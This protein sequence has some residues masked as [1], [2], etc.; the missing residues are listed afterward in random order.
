M[1][2][3]NNNNQGYIR[4]CDSKRIAGIQVYKAKLAIGGGSSNNAATTASAASTKKKNRWSIIPKQIRLYNA[5]FIIIY[6]FQII[7]VLL[8]MG[9]PYNEFIAKADVEGFQV[10]EGNTRLRAEFTHYFKEINAADRRIQKIGWNDWKHM[11]IEELVQE[12]KKDR[13][14]TVLDSIP[15]HMRIPGKYQTSFWPTLLFGMLCTI[16]AFILLLQHWNVQFNIYMNYIECDINQSIDILNRLYPNIM[17]INAITNPNDDN[18]SKKDNASKSSSSNIKYKL[19][20]NGNPIIFHNYEMTDTMSSNS[21]N[22]PTHAKIISSKKTE[23]DVLVPILFYPSL[24]MCIEYHRRKYIYNATEQIWSKIRCRTNFTLSLLYNTKQQQESKSNQK[25]W[26]GFPSIQQMIAAQIR[27]GPNIFQVKQPTFIEMYKVQLL[28][29]FSVFQIFCVLL[30]AIDSYIMY[31]MFSLFMIFMFEGTVVFQRLQSFKALQSMGNKNRIIYVYRCYQWIQLNTTELLPGDIISLTLMKPHHTSTNS[32]TTTNKSLTTTATTSSTD[33][34]TTTTAAKPPPTTTTTASPFTIEDDGG[35]VI[36]AD[37][38][39]L[40][41]STV[42]NEASLTGESVPQMK[43]GIT[44]FMLNNNEF[45]SLSIKTQHKMNVVYAGTKMLLCQSGSGNNNSNDTTTNTDNTATTDLFNH[46]PLPP[47]NGCTCFVLRTGFASAQGKLVRMIEGSQEKVKG[48][49]KET[50]LLLLML[51]VFAMISSSY[52]LYMGMQ[53][54]D[55]SKYELLLHCIIIVTNVIRPELPMQMA[56]AVNTSLMTLL[57]LHVFCTEP[58][59]VPVAGKLDICLFD[60]TGTLTTDELVAV[61]VCELKQ[62]IKIKSISTT[63]TPTI[64]DNDND[65]LNDDNMFTKLNSLSNSI[66]SV[67]LAGCHSLVVYENETTGDPLESAALRAMKWNI[68]SDTNNAEPKL[69]TEVVDPITKKNKT[70]TGGKPIILPTHYY[71]NTNNSNTKQN[72]SNSS[73]SITIQEVKIITRHH[74]SSKLQ[75]MSCVIQAGGNNMKWVVA[76]G[77]PEAIGQLLTIKP[78]GYDATS[79]YLAKQGYRVIAL[80]YKPLEESSGVDVTTRS[81]CETSLI[82]AGFIAFTCMVRRDTSDVLK[83]LKEGGMDI[84]MITG[85]ALLTAIHVAKEVHIVGDNNDYDFVVN[86]SELPKEKDDPELLKNEELRRFIEE[87]RA[88]NNTLKEKK[89]QEEEKKK[90]KNKKANNK[91]KPIIYLDI[92]VENDDK[93]YWKSYTD[94]NYVCDFIPKDIPQLSKQYDL[95]TTGKCLQIALADDVM[96]QVLQYIKIYARMTPDMKE[97]VIECLHSI[98]LL[99]LMCGDGMYIFYLYISCLVSKLFYSFYFMLFTKCS[100][101]INKSNM[102]CIWFCF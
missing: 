75:R 85:D 41:G 15:K 30:W 95:A 54:K 88:A 101:E 35:D 71:Y 97:T 42:V 61:G 46:I 62:L 39:L 51:M 90:N 59:R 40:R 63:T 84:A 11:D 99:C 77:S 73:N 96:K 48:H 31:S 94:G 13:E 66:A 78:D 69:T 21:T 60:K 7:Q 44:D 82:F 89:M 36:P 64:N 53:N 33:T 70:I 93:L 5:I 52:V 67:V 25:N 49:E 68:S 91:E 4:D 27:Y 56:L 50:G 38:L 47:D 43:E 92:N 29:P 65:Q 81:L 74:F 23:K 24:G 86:S 79:E 20:K 2:N 1:K 102:A 76:K 32:T 55:R 83:R 22:L 58:Y 9:V 19:D 37:L 10:M 100:N 45:L 8:T 26:I 14:K 12:K 18:D 87:K 3:P 34:A 17:D 16:H 57:K 6:I 72:G 80:A 28:N 98:H